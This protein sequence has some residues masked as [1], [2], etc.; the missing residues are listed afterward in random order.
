[1]KKLIILLIFAIV[2]IANASKP[3]PVNSGD[4]YMPGVDLGYRI[5][6]RNIDFDDGAYQTFQRTVGFDDITE[7]VGGT[8]KTFKDIVGV[9][10]TGYKGFYVMAMLKGSKVMTF[11]KA[12][13]KAEIIKEADIAYPGNVSAGMDQIEKLFI[14]EGL[15][16]HSYYTPPSPHPLFTCRNLLL[17]TMKGQSTSTTSL[18]SQLVFGI[19]IGS[20]IVP[21]N[22]PEIGLQPFI[23]DENVSLVTISYD[24]SKGIPVFSNSK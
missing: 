4:P 20:D 18:Y 9:N 10:I 6:I 7:Y 11:N 22:I 19:E 13:R 16:E 2:T 3:T 1:M 21:I 14:S 17:P 15:N 23:V 8:H 24:P 5:V 12:K